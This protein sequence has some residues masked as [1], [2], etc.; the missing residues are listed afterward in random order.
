V[1]I[2]AYWVGAL[3][4][5]GLHRG[6][7]GLVAR[8]TPVAF[9]VLDSCARNS[10]GA[11]MCVRLT[12]PNGNM[13]VGSCGNATDRGKRFEKGFGG[14]TS[15]GSTLQRRRGIGPATQWCGTTQ[16]KAK[17]KTSGRHFRDGITPRF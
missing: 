12:P 1:W 6:A 11:V 16:V 10:G 17:T 5:I 9:A 4:S 14:G 13:V 15:G 7:H 2:S 3:M 8:M